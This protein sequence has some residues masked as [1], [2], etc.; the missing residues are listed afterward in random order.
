M[1]RGGRAPGAGG[2]PADLGA[3]PLK[4]NAAVDGSVPGEEERTSGAETAG[5]GTRPAAE[6]EPPAP[7]TYTIRKGDS[8]AKIARKILGDE[9]WT[10]AIVRENPGVDPFRLQ[11]GDVIRLPD[12]A[13]LGAERGARKAGAEKTR[14][15]SYI[16]KEND[17]L[18]KIAEKVFGDK[19]LWKKIY[20]ANRDILLDP[21]SLIPGM[22]LRI[23]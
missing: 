9:K 11:V 8:F 18:C 15:K 13:A 20:D 3:T 14:G 5:T 19:R 4:V 16:V 23:P 17:S 22:E 2:V 1:G 21:D 10:K 12:I 6:P 7:R